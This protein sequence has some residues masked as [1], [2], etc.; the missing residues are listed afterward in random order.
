MFFKKDSQ[1]DSLLQSRFTNYLVV[2][3]RRRK[4]DIIQSRIRRAEKESYVDLEE[5]FF[6]LSSAEAPLEELI[7]GE[8]S[9]IEDM[10][11]KNERLERALWTLTERDRYVLFAK[12]LAERSFEELA[13]EFGI[14]YKGITAVYA[15]AI[16]KLKKEM[17][18]ADE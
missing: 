6:A 18:D 2:A 9:S 5:Y 3:V 15:R 4:K 8:P 11:F 1:G 16:R 7:H 14:S 10:Y 13:T 12:V 17:G